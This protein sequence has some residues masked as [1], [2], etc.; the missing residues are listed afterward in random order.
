MT[1]IKTIATECVDEFA[2]FH[3]FM[4]PIMSVSR[5]ASLLSVTISKPNLLLC[6]QQQCT[7]SFLSITRED[8]RLSSSL[9]L[10][11]CFCLSLVYYP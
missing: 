8:S 6:C 5:I 3:F 2:D 7:A 10:N 9:M 1:F 11:L 4:A